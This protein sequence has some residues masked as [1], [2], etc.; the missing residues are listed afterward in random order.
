MHHSW[1]LVR[2]SLTRLS[3]T[4]QAQIRHLITHGDH[5]TLLFI[6]RGYTE[7]GSVKYCR[8]PRRSSFSSRLRNQPFRRRSQKIALNLPILLWAEVHYSVYAPWITPSI[9]LDL[10]CMTQGYCA[11][12]RSNTKIRLVK[13]TPDVL[14]GRREKSL[15]AI[16]AF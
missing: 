5:I 10:T 3:H 1:F 8:R 15:S 2:I 9:Y 7:V 11:A 14:I 16:W 13:K 6:S 4:T 12:K